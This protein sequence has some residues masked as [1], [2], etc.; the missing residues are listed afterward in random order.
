M[1]VFMR[2]ITFVIKWNLSQIEPNLPP[3]EFVKLKKKNNKKKQNKKKNQ[4][5]KKPTQITD[6]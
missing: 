2:L 4:N 6:Q 3:F 5:K 1:A